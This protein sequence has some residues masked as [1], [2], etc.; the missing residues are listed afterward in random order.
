MYIDFSPCLLSND[1]EFVWSTIKSAVYSGMNLFIPKVRSPL[2]KIAQDL[3]LTANSSS[4]SQEQSCKA[5]ITL[6]EYPVSGMHSH[7]FSLAN[8]SN[9][10]ELAQVTH[11]FW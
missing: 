5:I 7:Q 4:Q 10:S 2:T 3:A 9:A 1:I 8:S 11:V 6:T